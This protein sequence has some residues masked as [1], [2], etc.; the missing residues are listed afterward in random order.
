MATSRR[1]RDAGVAH[2]SRVFARTE[3]GLLP[4]RA[5]A[6]KEA[7][8]LLGLRTLGGDRRTVD[9]MRRIAA[10]QREVSEAEHWLLSLHQYCTRPA[11]A[12]RPKWRGRR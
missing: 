3:L 11:A 2:R 1:P 8:R 7:R 6:L 10:L 12:L 4:G 5:K 9:R